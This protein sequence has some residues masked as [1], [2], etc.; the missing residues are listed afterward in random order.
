MG[1]ELQ[2][3]GR[4]PLL[5]FTNSDFFTVELPLRVFVELLVTKKLCCV[6][7]ALFFFCI[8]IPLSLFETAYLRFSSFGNDGISIV[9]TDK[10]IPF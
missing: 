9:V 4:R 6:V 10:P 3:E 1:E 2:D 5:F 7:E 8:M